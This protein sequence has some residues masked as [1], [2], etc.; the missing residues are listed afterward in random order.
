M[1]T[2]IEVPFVR[3][4]GF[5]ATGFESVA[6]ARPPAAGPPSDVQKARAADL[7]LRGA[8]TPDQLARAKA[9]REG[10]EAVIGQSNFLP[11]WFLEVGAASG[12]ATCQ[13][14][15]SGVDYRGRTGSWTG[16]G[17]LLGS[18]VLVT[19]HHV[20]NSPAV[21]GAGS[22]V[23]D[24][25]AGPD[26]R[27]L[28]PRS[29][30]LRP[31][32]L[33]LTSPAVGGLDFTFCWVDA[34]PDRGF[35]AV[36]AD[37]R[38]FGVAEGEFANVI[39]HPAGRMK[40]VSLQQNEV[41]WQDDL[42]VHYTSDTEPG[43]SGAAV[44]NNNW[45]LVALHH[46]SRPSNVPG[47][48]VLNEGIKLSAIA[49]DLERLAR[50]GSAAA[51]ELLAL[52]DGADER[53]GFFGGLGRPAGPGGGLEAV[54]DTFRGTERDLDVGFWNVEWLTKHYDT[55]T[56]AVAR[57][58]RELNLD[59]W[60]L[61]ESS[62]NA[63]AA[64]AA[65]LKDTYGLDYGH[66]AAE[67]EK[68]DGLQ[69]CTLLWDRGTAEVTPE[70]WGEPIETWLRAHS[71]DFAD[72]GLGGFEA[73]H[74]NI[75]DRY[76]ALF[77]VTSK[78]D[79]PA[80]VP[81]SFYLVP[82]HLK[83]MAEGS[84]RRR[85]A[86]RI[87]AEAVSR[88]AAG[89]EVSDFVVGGDANAPLASGDFTNLTDS[90]L[91]AASAA[92]AAGG[93]FS[94][95]KG[96]KSLIDHVFLSPN[97]A[98]DTAADFFVVAADRTFPDYLGEIS[99]HRPVLV[100]LS[101]GDG[102]APEAQFETAGRAEA[103]A[104]LRGLLAG[105][106]LGA[107]GF[108]AARRGPNLSGRTG[109]DPAFLGGGVAIPLP[110]PAAGPDAD[111]VVVDARRRGFDR[112]VLAYTHFSVVMNGPRRMPF[113]SAVNIDGGKLRRFSRGDNWFLDP[114]IGP[115]VQTGNE[116]YANNALDRGHMTR[117]L[118][119]VWGPEA[120]ARQADADTF[121]FTNA[122]PQ[123][124]DL[125]QKEW[126]R[127][128]DYVLENAGAH[129]LKVCVL[130]GPVFAAGDPA[131]RGVRLPQQFW[132][133]V[134][135]RRADTGRAS[136]TAYLLSQQDLVSG[137]EFVFGQFKTYQVKVSKVAALTGLDF[138]GLASFDPLTGRGGFEA[139]GAEAVEVT[140]PE[141]LVF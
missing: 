71:T 25:Q 108:E 7:F 66:A 109:Y 17:F 141:S 40:E 67:P 42:V 59:V 52:F 135:I 123:H 94:Y 33:F 127:L 24:Y 132:K 53:L 99:D 36:R 110:R 112:H 68:P 133:V 26:G 57:V 27:P 106:D 23:F 54:V 48:A 98:A 101:L 138:G 81:L 14:R 92:D 103:L 69:S 104:E 119:P 19:N 113:Y 63:A 121:C 35:G 90:G 44:C 39:S 2:P 134:A 117:R 65:E 13:L 137:F 105:A 86:S 136:V 31:D 128:E 83:A 30:P 139:A 32:R 80:G 9:S 12:R 74:G 61:E 76:P 100:R 88:K 58:I 72:L 124:K 89:G 47:H 87:L 95:I 10:F 93:A 78:Q 6:P 118:D 20:L 75:F 1:P 130:T 60:C 56:P 85:M 82:L 4:S 51:A 114:R 122:C 70:P 11:A 111:P 50:A 28:T 91:V 3:S 16:T 96:P 73:V 41:Q 84:L 126:A 29:V 49:A 107:E 116:V 46:A 22:A 8:L 97:L 38:A 140:G 64:V 18:N 125:N 5:E 55:K 115:G 129:D 77:R 120:V 102:A 34:D 21:A 37:R 15:T 79:G 131:Y 45:Q 43:S 62:A